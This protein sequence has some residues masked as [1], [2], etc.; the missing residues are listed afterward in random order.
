MDALF[1]KRHVENE[2][3]LYKAT[4]SGLSTAVAP[5]GLVSGVITS[6]VSFA[7]GN[8]FN[9]LREAIEDV[10][11]IGAG[12]RL[13][14]KGA[15]AAKFAGKTFTLELE[16]TRKIWN[17]SGIPQLSISLAF[18]GL[19]SGEDRPIDK[20]RALYSSLFPTK[21]A[22]SFIVN[23]PLGYK[24]IEGKTLEASGTLE[25]FIGK[26]F[27][28]KGLVATSANFTPSIE[29]MRDG[30]PLYMSGDITLESYKM[31]TYEEFL[32]WFP[33]SPTISGAGIES[34]AL[35]GVTNL[36]QV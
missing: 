7:A 16:Q 13:V 22:D 11:L 21:A 26:Y 30:S 33:N 31:V 29:V 15:E 36:G 17:N 18:Y 20:V 3:S 6:P 32:Q 10:P 24:F 5:K 23:A 8:D 12:A 34:S 19:R 25:L 2:D 14:R 35:A 27:H 9:S 4:I 1:Y 28:A